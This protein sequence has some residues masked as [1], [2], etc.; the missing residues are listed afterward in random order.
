MICT[1]CNTVQQRF[2]LTEAMILNN[3]QIHSL[4]PY[5]A[6]VCNLGRFGS[7]L[8]GV[9]Y[10]G[11]FWNDFSLDTTI[12]IWQRLCRIWYNTMKTLEL[13]T[14][15]RHKIKSTD[16][17]NDKNTKIFFSSWHLLVGIQKSVPV[18]SNGKYFL[19]RKK[20]NRLFNL[21]TRVWGVG[22]V[23][24]DP[25]CTKRIILFIHCVC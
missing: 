14:S 5:W 16:K 4:L 25:A 9:W 22:L 10:V 24:I 21:V 18:K 13:Y 7:K 2:T 3:I 12:A 19:N 23:L 15:T 20:N 17:W 11:G 6:L 8:A 1:N